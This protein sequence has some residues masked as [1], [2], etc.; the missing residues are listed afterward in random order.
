MN[1]LD[2]INELARLRDF[3]SIL[4]LVQRCPLL[5]ELGQAF[6]KEGQTIFFKLILVPN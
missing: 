3:V 6:D 4:P 5:R 2:T 1:T